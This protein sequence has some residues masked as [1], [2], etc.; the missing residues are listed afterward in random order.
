MYK[1]LIRNAS[2]EVLEEI[3][4]LLKYAKANRLTIDSLI[5]AF[6]FRLGELGMEE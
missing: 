5:A 1:E 3:L 6:E 2:I 4:A